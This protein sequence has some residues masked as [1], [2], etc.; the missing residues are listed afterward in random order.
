[1]PMTPEQFDAHVRK[2]IEI[3]RALVKEAGIVVN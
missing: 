2:E 1:M 3:N